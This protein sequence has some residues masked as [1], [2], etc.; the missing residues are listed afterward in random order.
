MDWALRF[1]VIVLVGF[2]L[3]AT[4]ALTVLVPLLHQVGAALT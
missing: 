2:A 3:V 4:V 1:A